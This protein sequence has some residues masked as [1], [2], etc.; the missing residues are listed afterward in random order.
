M[1]LSRTPY[2][3]AYGYPVGRAANRAAVALQYGYVWASPGL[4]V[5]LE[6][7]KVRVS[8][9]SASTGFTLRLLTQAQQTT[10]G[11]DAFTNM[12]R[13]RQS[14]AGPAGP[15]FPESVGSVLSQG[16][17]D[18]L[19]GSTVASGLF[20]LGGPDLEFDF[21]GL[22]ITLFGAPQGSPTSIQALAVVCATVN[23]PFDVTFFCREW[24]LRA[25]GG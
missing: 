6:I 16:T 20:V 3:N 4:N 23:L 5:C 14:A 17:H 18:A 19:V 11:V 8:Q 13:L 25:T 9:C 10:V 7:V 22:G 21:E 15:T 1:L 2:A 12:L 24:P